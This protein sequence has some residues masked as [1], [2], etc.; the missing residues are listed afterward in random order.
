[1]RKSEVGV[2]L[3][4]R[5]ESLE[6]AAAELGYLVVRGGLGPARERSSVATRDELDRKL[7]IPLTAYALNPQSKVDDPRAPRV[8]RAGATP[9]VNALDLVAKRLVDRLGGTPHA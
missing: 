1:M 4:D 5:G 2:L 7:T 3:I 8:Q 6:A 9:L